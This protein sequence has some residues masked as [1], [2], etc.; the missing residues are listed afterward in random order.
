[1][2]MGAASI[3][4]TYLFETKNFLNHVPK[5]NTFNRPTCQSS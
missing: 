3:V 4:L 5:S 2:L 1:M